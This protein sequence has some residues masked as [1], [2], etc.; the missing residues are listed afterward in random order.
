MI[1]EPQI[2]VCA[3]AILT[4]DAHEFSAIETTCP[5]GHDLTGRGSRGSFCGSCGMALKDKIVPRYR[6]KHL[7]DLED[8]GIEVDKFAEIHTKA[9][10]YAKEPLPKSRITLMSN[11]PDG[12]HCDKLS[13]SALEITPSD[14][15]KYTAKF[16]ELYLSELSQYGEVSIHFGLLSNDIGLREAYSEL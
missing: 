6:D 4:T 14:I 3:Y 8:E 12:T 2:H 1:D 9:T 5:K 16:A 10:T 7:R 13:F 15:A 11:R